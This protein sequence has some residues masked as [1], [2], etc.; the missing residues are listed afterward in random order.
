MAMRLLI[1]I[2]NIC[3]LTACQHAAHAPVATAGGGG[4]IYPVSHYS[5]EDG[6]QLAVRLLGESAEVGINGEGALSLPQVQSVSDLMVYSNGRQTLSI[7]AGQTS[8][9][10]GRAVPAACSAD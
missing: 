2:T 10:L 6:T 3:V 5:C 1:A 9:A 8:W 7:K 4:P